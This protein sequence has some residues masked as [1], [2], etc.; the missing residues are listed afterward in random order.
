ML[1]ASLGMGAHGLGGTRDYQHVRSVARASSPGQLKCLVGGASGTLV[2]GEL[3]D[4]GRM[5]CTLPAAATAGSTDVTVSLNNGATGTFSA[6]EVSFVHYTPPHIV[7]T[8]PTEG[9]AEGGTTVVVYG[10]GFGALS[11][12]PGLIK[13][14]FGDGTPPVPAISSDDASVTCRPE[15]GVQ[16]PFGAP[17]RIA[18]W[19]R[20]GAWPFCCVLGRT[21]VLGACLPGA[22]LPME[23]CSVGQERAPRRGFG[24]PSG[25]K[26]S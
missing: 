15:W 23:T 12:H 22:L 10:S 25:R 8:K 11:A 19:A 21:R 3:L 7:S 16:D 14:L 17:V 13:C 24:A 5:L 18:C 2:S 26:L 9:E 1:T 6:D 20:A 4:S